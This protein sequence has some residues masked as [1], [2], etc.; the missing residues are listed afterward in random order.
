[1]VDEQTGVITTR[2]MRYHSIGGVVQA[3]P[4]A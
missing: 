3:Q 2:K 4:S 1:V